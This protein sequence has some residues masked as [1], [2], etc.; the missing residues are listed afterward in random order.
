MSLR[1]HL[2]ILAGLSVFSVGTAQAQATACAKPIAPQKAAPSVAP[3]FRVEVVAN[4]L[5]DPRSLLFD[6]QGGLLVVEQGHG[7]SRLSL[8]GDGACVQVEGQVQNVVEDGSVSLAFV[9]LFGASQG[10]TN[11]VS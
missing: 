10:L 5:R 9:W 4:G 2:G 3:G 8:T 1:R 7:I 11:N 6:Q